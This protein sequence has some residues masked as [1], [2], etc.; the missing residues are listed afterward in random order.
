MKPTLDELILRLEEKF[1]KLNMPTNRCTEDFHK[2][3]QKLI[4][5]ILSKEVVLVVSANLLKDKIGG[6]K[7]E[8]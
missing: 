1:G 3:Y 8:R 7:N 5:S 6:S 2:N 4:N